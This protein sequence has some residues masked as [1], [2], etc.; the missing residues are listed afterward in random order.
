VVSRVLMASVLAA[1][2]PSAVCGPGTHERSGVC[3]LDDAGMGDAG[4]EAAGMNDA[5]RETPDAGPIVLPVDVYEIDGIGREGTVDAYRAL[6]RSIGDATYIGLGESIHTSG[7]YY[8]AKHRIFRHLV[9]EHGVR[10][11]AIESPWTDADRV[12]A[13]VDT[14]EGDPA[15]AVREGLF[16]VWASD[17]LLDLVRWMCEWNGAHEDDRIVFYGF[18]VQQPFDDAPGLREWLAIVAGAEATA[19]ADGFSTCH[20]VGSEPQSEQTHA[21]CLA[22]LDALDAWIAANEEAVIAASST[23]ELEYARIRS[24]GLRSWELQMF[25]FY[26][27]GVDPDLVQMLE[28]RDRGMADV[29]L[30]MRALRSPGAR[31]AVWAHNTHLAMA[32][33]SVRGH[34]A[35]ARSMGTFLRE[36]VGDDYAPIA[37]IGYD[38]QIDWLGQG[39]GSIGLPMAH[40]AVELELHALGVPYAYVD[41]GAS[42]EPRLVELGEE[43][44]V[45]GNHLVPDEQFVGL[46]FLDVSEP[47]SPLAW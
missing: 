9:E 26:D 35:G 31:V 23:E 27:G 3:V 8:R 37:L 28:G 46:F 39:Y 11:F 2:G 41:L 4:M 42:G 19:L 45:Q 1:C 17:E 20:G 30:R 33:P 24:I 36:I 44:G 6:D 14:C 32:Q 15:A 18:D 47:M 7:G 34:Y 12:A 16:G 29:L 43:I 38:V 5:G 13:Y 40:D 10:A 22:G 25:H 21:A